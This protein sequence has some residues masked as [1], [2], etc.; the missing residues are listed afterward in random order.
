MLLKGIIYGDMRNI[1]LIITFM[2]SG[3]AIGVF[4]TVQFFNKKHEAPTITDSDVIVE[5]IK[6]VKKVIVTEGIF[7]EIYS[8]KDAKAY[9]FDVV[10]FEKKALLLIKGK[11]Y[12]SYDL[13]LIDYQVDEENRTITLVNIPAPEIIIEPELKYYDLQQSS[14][15][16][17]SS[18]DYNKLQSLA[19]SKLKVKVKQSELTQMARNNLESTL[20]DLQI[21][22]KELGWKILV[23]KS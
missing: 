17:F 11:A 19:K 7:S 15:N 12:V 9:F 22:G 8:Y 6:A 1:I 3:I 13:E 21:I 10:R 14:F 18:A 2:V 20:N 5:R 23:R 4:T 16:T